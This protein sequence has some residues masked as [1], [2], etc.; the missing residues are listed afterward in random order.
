M[1]EASPPTGRYIAIDIDYVGSAVSYR[2]SYHSTVESGGPIGPLAVA[3]ALWDAGLTVQTGTVPVE[4]TW[5]LFKQALPPAARAMKRPWWDLVMTLAYMRFNY[6]HFNH[7][8]APGW[9]E[10]DCVLAE[11]IDTLVDLTVAF[12]AKAE[13]DGSAFAALEEAFR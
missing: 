10:G 2:V 12:H 7:T 5:A 13:H 6:R 11:R 1:H 9:T 8:R 3:V 4:R